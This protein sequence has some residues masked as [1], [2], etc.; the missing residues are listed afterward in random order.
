MRLFSKILQ[1]LLIRC[2]S[3]FSKNDAMKKKNYSLILLYFITKIYR[4]NE[5]STL[6]KYP[7]YL[8]V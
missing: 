4:E 6:E 1:W 5:R 3:F 7:V 8:K 2:F